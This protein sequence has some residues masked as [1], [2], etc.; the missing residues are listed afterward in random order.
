VPVDRRVALDGGRVQL[1][2]QVV[3]GVVVVERASA[4]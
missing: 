2:Q 4:R 1:A 3:A